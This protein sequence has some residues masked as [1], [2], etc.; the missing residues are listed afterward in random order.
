MSA[1]APEMYNTSV[2]QQVMKLHLQHMLFQIL[3]II[4]SY[5]N[6]TENMTLSLTLSFII[7]FKGCHMTD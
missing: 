1:A 4:L 2:W 6:R 5:N 3:S 7:F